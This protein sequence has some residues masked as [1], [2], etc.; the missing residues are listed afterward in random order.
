M[1]LYHFELLSPHHDL[2]AS[3]ELVSSTSRQSLWLAQYQ[4]LGMQ[5]TFFLFFYKTVRC[6]A[7]GAMIYNLWNERNFHFH[8]NKATPQSQILKRIRQDVQDR[9]ASLR[10]VKDNSRIRELYQQWGF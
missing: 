2:E 7:F 4:W 3:F 10:G 9:V 1:E 6:L 5:Q 8:E